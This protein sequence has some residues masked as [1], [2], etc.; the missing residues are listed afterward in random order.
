MC[1]RDSLK[2]GES[3]KAHAEFILAAFREA[4]VCVRVDEARYDAG[5]AEV[6]LKADLRTVKPVRHLL[7]R[8]DLFDKAVFDEHGA[9]LLLHI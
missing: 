7:V 3:G 8:P 2:V 1:I 6:P 4:E 9:C 5:A